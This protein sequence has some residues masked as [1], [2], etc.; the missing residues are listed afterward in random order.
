M[1]PEPVDLDEIQGW[2][3]EEQVKFWAFEHFNIIPDMPFVPRN[4]GWNANWC[5][6]LQIKTEWLFSKIIPCF[7]HITRLEA[8]RE[9]RASLATIQILQEE[10]LITEVRVKGKSLKSLLV[11]QIIKKNPE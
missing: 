6:H 5:F 4:G 2:I 8:I 11:T 3:W 7:G 1:K 9:C 10:N